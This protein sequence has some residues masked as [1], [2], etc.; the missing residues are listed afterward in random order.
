VESDR[1][2]PLLFQL[3]Y[4]IISQQDDSYGGTDG[5]MVSVQGAHQLFDLLAAASIGRWT[6]LP[7]WPTDHLG[8]VNMQ[9]PGVREP[10]GVPGLY[11]Q[12]MSQLKAAGV[13]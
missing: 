13:E 1:G 9:F 3:S 11:Q 6:N 10:I 12:L 8:A 4:W 2:I 5:G 7:N